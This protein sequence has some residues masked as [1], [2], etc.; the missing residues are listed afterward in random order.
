MT[1]STSTTP[2]VTS[3]AAPSPERTQ[4]I[5]AA[6]KLIFDL[7]GMKPPPA[8]LITA[9]TFGPMHAFVDEL[10]AI[11]TAS[12]GP[13][14]TPNA[15]AA[16][17][18]PTPVIYVDTNGALVSRVSAEQVEAM[19]GPV[20][21]EIRSAMPQKVGPSRQY[22]GQ[23]P[24]SAL[25]GIRYL[26]STLADA[27]AIAG[28]ALD[29]LRKRSAS[30]RPE[31]V[32]QAA[33]LLSE[34]QWDRKGNVIHAA[35]DRLGAEQRVAAAL[36][37]DSP[38][39]PPGMAAP[40]TWVCNGN[41][42]AKVREVHAPSSYEPAGCYDLVFYGRD[43]E[44]IGRESP[45]M[46]GPRGYEPFCSA[47]CW[48]AIEAPRFPLPRYGDLSEKVK[49]KPSEGDSSKGAHG[50]AGEDTEDAFQGAPRP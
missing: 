50:P 37:D 15:P 5:E 10:Q 11:V 38:A 26:A 25:Y 20:V 46:G 39:M 8:E 22:A 41:R 21:D 23:G 31:Q 2:T 27:Q 42:V 6:A 13:L 1:I 7:L 40:G 18:L 49:F 16:E 28:D 45:A 9:E 12:R 3:A 29:T 48:R 33:A 35:V 43:G 4:L 17:V 47:G 19:L 14:A 24:I 32:S 36:K 30:R 44:R 34:P